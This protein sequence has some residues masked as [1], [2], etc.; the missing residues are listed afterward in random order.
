MWLQKR[1][2]KHGCSTHIAADF[3]NTKRI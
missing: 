3:G 1:E 2:D